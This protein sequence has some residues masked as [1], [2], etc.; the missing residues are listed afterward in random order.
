MVRLGQ[1]APNFQGQ[2]YVAGRLKNISLA[3]ILEEW[4]VLFFY[5]KDFTK[6]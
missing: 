6:I 3:E 1:A 2:A 5:V 4:I